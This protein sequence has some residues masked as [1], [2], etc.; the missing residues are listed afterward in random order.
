LP[1]NYYDLPANN[2]STILSLPDL[3]REDIDEYYK[4]FTEL[5]IRDRTKVLPKDI[6]PIYRSKII[7][8]VE[9]CASRG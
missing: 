6:D 9:N 2:R 8:D 1:K 3:T 4:M 5:R 7:E